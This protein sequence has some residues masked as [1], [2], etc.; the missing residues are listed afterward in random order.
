MA[1]AST[2]MQLTKSPT[3]CPSP[4]TMLNIDQQGH[5]SPC[6]SCTKMIGNIK[7]NTIQEVINGPVR[8]EMYKAMMAGEWPEGC[9]WCKRQEETTG[10]IG[11][12]H[13]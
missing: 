6:F 7:E 8:K 2:F 12:A 4:W 13:V 10:E 3:F 9:G 5:T 11:R 1:G